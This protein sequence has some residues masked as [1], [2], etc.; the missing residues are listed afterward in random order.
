MLF[1][2][3]F[4]SVLYVKVGCNDKC[5]VVNDIDGVAVG[6]LV[7]GCYVVHREPVVRLFIK[8][9]V[10]GGFIGWYECFRGVLV[11][12]CIVPEFV[13]KRVAFFLEFDLFYHF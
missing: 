2:H 12:N 10:V 4:Y 9:V 6:F 8:L 13:L 3:A 11:F 1:C 5:F 7:G